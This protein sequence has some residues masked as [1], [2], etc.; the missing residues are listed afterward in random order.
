M[1]LCKEL[2]CLNLETDDYSNSRRYDIPTDGLVV[3]E[4]VFLFRPELA[5]YLD[6]KIHLHIDFD[7]CL[8]RVVERDG[9]LFGSS[10]DIID[11]YNTKYIP[12]QILYFEEARPLQTADL[13]LDNTHFANSMPKK[14]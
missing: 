12:G 10:Q 14:Y 11:R 6:I 1:T 8:G 5:K 4:G 7:C 9:Y 13:I 2:M 3:I